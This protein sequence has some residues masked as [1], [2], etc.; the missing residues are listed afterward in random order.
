M[1]N[2]F[3]SDFDMTYMQSLM[4]VENLSRKCVYADL[5]FFAKSYL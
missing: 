4:N 2:D 5:C 3:C 1:T